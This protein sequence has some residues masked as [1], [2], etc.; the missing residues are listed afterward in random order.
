MAEGRNLLKPIVFVLCLSATIAGLVNV[1]GDNASVRRLAETAAC[2]TSN[3]S[4][5]MT[6]ES[7]SPISQ[8]FTF[9]TTLKGQQTVDV[10]CKREH[11]LFGEYACSKP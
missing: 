6:R 7:R 11:I 3:C 8:S 1:Y 4:V 2:G 10:E 9:Q 5:T